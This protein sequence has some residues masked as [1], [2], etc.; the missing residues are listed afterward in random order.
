MSL[1]LYSTEFMTRRECRLK[2]GVVAIEGQF[3]QTEGD[4]IY[5]LADGTTSNVYQ[6]WTGK[7]D[8][9]NRIEDGGDESGLAQRTDVEAI[10]DPYDSTGDGTLDKASGGQITGLFGQYI[11]ETDQYTGTIAIDGI[12]GDLTCASGKLVAWTEGDSVV[13]VVDEIP[14]NTDSGYLRYKRV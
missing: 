2:N 13:A 8:Q 3:V 1:K 7:H 9:S 12:N 4:N 14:A 10:M 5:I 11:A 6:V